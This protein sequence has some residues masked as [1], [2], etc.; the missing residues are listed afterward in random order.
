VEESG[1]LGVGEGKACA[2]VVG[3][4]GICM[5]SLVVEVV[6]SGRLGEGE[7]EGVG[8]GNG[9]EGVEEIGR[10]GVDEG[11]ACALVVVEIGRLG[12]DEGRACALVVVEMGSGREVVVRRLVEVEERS[13]SSGCR[14]F[15]MGG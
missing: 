14:R 6:G 5:A 12:V 13:R 8:E 7:G 4:M 3:E 1:K 10:L 2:L 9:E 15:E 11:R